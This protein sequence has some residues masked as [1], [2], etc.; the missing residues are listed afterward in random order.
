MIWVCGKCGSREVESLA[1]VDMNTDQVL[2]GTGDYDDANYWC[3][4]CN[5]HTHIQLE[6]EYKKENE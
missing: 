3:R 5:E 6:S 4:K 2:D 1:W